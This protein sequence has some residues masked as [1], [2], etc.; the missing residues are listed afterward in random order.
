M[1]SIT[2][3]ITTVENE[4]PFPHYINPAR[5]SHENIAKTVTTFLPRESSILD[6]GAGPCDVSAVL[7]AL[8]YRCTAYD[9]LEDHWH[10]IDDNKEKILDFA[11][12]SGIDFRLA[13]RNRLPFRDAEF[14]MI[15]LNDVLE[16]LHDSPRDLLLQ[17]LRLLKPGGYLLI[18]VPNAVNI[19][20]RLSVI[21][22]K[23]NLPDF[24]YFFWY[25]GGWRGHVREYSKEDLKMLAEYMDLKVKRLVS[26]HHMLSKL[27]AALR[28]LYKGLTMLFPGWR[29]TW[30]LLGQKPERWQPKEQLTGA[31]LDTLLGRFSPYYMGWSASN[32]KEN[33]ST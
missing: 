32:Q 30:L 1:T 7:Q 17:L 31:E 3:A 22:G 23:T 11:L 10:K 25:P 20:K 27:P 13:T 33:A 15:M 16:H 24:D 21:M 6:F 5:G 9:D 4:F 14:D 29:D 2:K 18:T 28:W 19:R 8:G 12:K 26:C